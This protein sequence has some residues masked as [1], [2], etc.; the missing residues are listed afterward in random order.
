MVAQERS[1]ADLHVG[2]RRPG[3]RPSRRVKA[4]PIYIES[5]AD[6]GDGTIR[7]VND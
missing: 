4:R 5:E 7:A 1:E 6:E 2:S 3:S